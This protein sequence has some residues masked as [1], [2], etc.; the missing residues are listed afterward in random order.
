MVKMFLIYAKCVVVVFLLSGCNYRIVE[1][2]PAKT[3]T[4]I[5]IPVNDYCQDHPCNNCDY[6][7]SDW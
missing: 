4:P 7:I 6:Y 2:T 1:Q 5:Y 3:T